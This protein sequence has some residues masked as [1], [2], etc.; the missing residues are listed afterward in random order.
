MKETLWDGSSKNIY[1]TKQSEVILLTQVNAMS[2]C[3]QKCLWNI[4]L[5]FI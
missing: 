4:D 5:C 2:C 3:I 1:K